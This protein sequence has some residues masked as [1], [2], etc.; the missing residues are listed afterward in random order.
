[1]LKDAV[2]A[3]LH[4]IEHFA[5]VLPEVHGADSVIIMPPMAHMGRYG[6]HHTGFILYPA[7]GGGL[8]RL[9]MTAGL[10][11]VAPACALNPALTDTGVPA[12]ALSKLCFRLI[13][14]R[15]RPK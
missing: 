7:G 4:L 3:V 14:G 11:C 2:V 12:P 15:R 1:M 9:M 13:L 5:Q 6:H 10:P 8:S